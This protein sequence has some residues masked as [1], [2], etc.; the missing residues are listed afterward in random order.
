MMVG[1]MS[2]KAIKT[3]FC[4]GIGVRWHRDDG[5]RVLIAGGVRTK[6]RTLELVF[7]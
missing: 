7:T 1:K 3:G 4:G 5:A 2:R 6:A